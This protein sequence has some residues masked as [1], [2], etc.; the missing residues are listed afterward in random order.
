LGKHR[1]KP[2][3]IEAFQM[4]K[5]RRWDNSEWPTWLNMAWNR[6]HGENA[7]WPDPDTPPEPGN[8]SSSI[9]VYG[10]LDGVRVITPGDY[11][12]QGSNGELSTCKPDVFEALTNRFYNKI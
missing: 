12:I 9:L 4:T 11:I 6:E 10:T 3:V 7:L 8:Q 1:K 2:V 5:E